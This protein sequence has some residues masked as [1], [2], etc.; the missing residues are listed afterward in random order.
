M[1]EEIE[2]IVTATGFDKVSTGLKNTN[3]ALKTTATEAKKTGDALKSNL[4]AG[5]AQAGQSLQNLSRIAQD[6]PFGFIGIANNIN[7]LV[8]SFGRLKAETG[9]TGGALKALVS[10]LSGPAGLG[11]AFGVVTAAITFAQIGFDRWG[12]SA[13]KAKEAVD[14]VK[15]SQEEFAKSLDTARAGALSNGLALQAYVDIAKNGQL[16]LEQRNEALKKANE[17][18]GKHGELLTLTNVGTEAATREVELYTRAIVAQAV[19]QKYVDQLATNYVERT[20]LQKELTKNQDAYNFAVSE[21]AR[22]TKEASDAVRNGAYGTNLVTNYYKAEDSARQ[23]LYSTINKIIL[24][25]N[26]IIGQNIDLSNS[27]REAT[28][29]FG[30]LGTKTTES[31]KKKEK[32]KKTV[33]TLQDAYKSFIQ[34]LVDNQNIALAFNEP[35]TKENI[36]AY[37]TFIETAIKKFNANRAFTLPLVVELNALKKSLEVVKPEDLV[38]SLQEKINLTPI[39]IPFEIPTGAIDNLKQKT[40][41]AVSDLQKSLQQSFQIIGVGLGEALGAALSGTTDFSSIF[42]GIFQQLGGVVQQLGESILAIGIAGII[43]SDSLKQIFLNPYAAIAAGI[44]LVALGSLIQNATAP[45]NRFAVGTRNAPGGMA[46]VGERGPELINL[47]RGSQ[48]IPAAQTSN[49]M[50]GMPAAVEI[51][52]ILRGQDIYFSNKKYSATYARTT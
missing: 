28:A 25:N 50:G 23:N 44:A 51:Y 7:P 21:T 46:L 19:T 48:V 12:S 22:V 42:Q 47:P 6:A 33:E 43:A 38:K 24:V 14:E 9:S 39:T 18:L 31:T 49:M 52:G 45:K 37:E 41:I 32:D 40:S 17:I 11:L 1:A 5:S 13:K 10:G 2:I 8:E 3:D 26:D 35:A 20:R 15:K 27:T 16:P 34:T 36:K 30:E 4:N 29:A